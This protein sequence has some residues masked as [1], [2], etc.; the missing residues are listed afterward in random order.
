M[1]EP[2][3]NTDLRTQF[4][5]NAIVYLTEDL[6]HHRR[7]AIK[8][9]RPELALA[10]GTRRSPLGPGHAPGPRAHD[11][12]G[13]AGAAQVAPK[14]ARRC[15][16]AAGPQPHPIEFPIA[17][18]RYCARNPV[19]LERLTYDR[20]ARAVMYRSDKSVGPTAGT[21]TVDPLEFLARVLVHIPDKGHV[22]TRYNPRRIVDP[23]RLKF[24][25]REKGLER[26]ILRRDILSRLP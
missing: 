20:A 18:S 13:L 16:R 11:P 7:V 23:P 3:I 22:T 8:M 26:T 10:L 24:L 19:A 1:A 21:E 6:K 9:L 14:P 15:S 5:Q 17:A 25:S 2:E 12:R 4:V